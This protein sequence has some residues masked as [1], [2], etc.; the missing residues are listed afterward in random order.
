MNTVNRIDPDIA[1]K[2][3]RA[4]LA[5]K[6]ISQVNICQKLSFSRDL[7]NKFLRRKINLLDEDIERVL[8]ELDLGE[9]SPKLSATARRGV[10]VVSPPLPH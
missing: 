3:I 5:A 9:L 10:S 7:F 6:M 8:T 1:A 2:A 4:S